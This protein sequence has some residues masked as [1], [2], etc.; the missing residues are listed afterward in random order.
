[1]SSASSS[2]AFALFAPS[3]SHGDFEVI[4][5]KRSILLIVA[6]VALCISRPTL[7]GPSDK[8]LDVYWSDTEGGAATLIVTPAGESVLVD[9]GN[10]GGRDARRIFDI[11][12]KIAG[13]K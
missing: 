6:L 4:R 11:A 10:A 12:T 3:R 9:S 1:M 7:A 2:R 13:L 8:R 5:M